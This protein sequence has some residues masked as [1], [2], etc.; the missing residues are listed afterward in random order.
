MKRFVWLV[1]LVLSLCAAYAQPRTITL[2]G[3]VRDKKQQKPVES[4]NVLVQ[5]AGHAMCGYA[6]TGEDGT[7]T[8]DCRVT[9]DT[10][11]LT[12]MAF[13]IKPVTRTVLAR[14]QR[15]DFVVEYSEMKIREVVVKPEAIK[16]RSDT[17]VYNVAAFQSVADRSI[18]DVLKKMPGITV[19]QS[20]AVKYNGKSINRFYV[21]GLDMMGSRYGVATKNIQAKDIAKVEVL[22]NHQPIRVLQG[23]QASDRAAV[24]LKLKNSARGTWNGTLQLGAGYAPVQWNGE[25][26]LMYFGRNFQTLNTYKTNNSGDDAGR[27]LQSFEGGATAGSL[28]IGV[29]AP[30]SPPVDR[31]RYLDN[32]VHAVSLNVIR[33]LKQ[34]GSDFRINA[35][36]LHDLQAA[37]GTSLTTCWR[38]D[39]P[40]LV[41][42]ERS[43]ADHRTDRTEVE[44]QLRKNTEKHYLREQL[45]FGGRWDRDAGTVWS[46]GSA[47]D[48][49]FRLPSIRLRNAFSDIVRRGDWSLNLYSTTDFA[50]Q[51]GELT[52]MPTP[53]AEIFGSPEGCPD[54]FQQLTS[55]RFRTDNSVS[56]FYRVKRWTFWMRVGAEITLERLTSSLSACSGPRER[57][58]A[59]DTMRNDLSWQLYRLNAGPSISYR[60]GDRFSASLSLPVELQHLRRNGRTGSEVFW[61]P[62]LSIQGT[63][64]YN[65]KYSA[66]ASCGETIGGI[67]D[68]YPGYIMSDYR[69]IASR[70]GDLLRTRR[71]NGSASLSYGNAIRALF[72]SLEGR[73]WRQR[74][75]LTYGTRYAGTLTQI[76][77]EAAPNT[78]RGWSVSGKLSKRFTAIATTV[79]LGG[80]YERSHSELLRQ[81]ERVDTRTDRVS[82]DAG[83]DARVTQALRLDYRGEYVRTQSRAAGSDPFDPIDFVHQ[84]AGVSLVLG[85]Q[86]VWRIG[87]EHYYN[88][89]I[90]GRDR[91]LWFLD[92]SLS[93]KGK[94]VEYVIEGSNL[95]DTRAFRSVSTSDLNDYVRSYTLRPA[96]VLFKVKFSLK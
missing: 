48:Q 86:W 41:I 57:L 28:P 92:A 58:E 62:S 39:A 79:N 16:R 53:Y 7:Y 3:C 77:T 69:Q 43:R 49:R 24:N 5:T 94:R 18:G 87:G 26:T 65:L 15:A 38:P 12:V 21:E 61:S 9:A 8:I 80:G 70:T 25:G 66:Q 75:N 29:H 78:S 91:N 44:L 81:G 37:R 90:G 68:T 54:A 36:Y 55:R 67:Y 40:P 45:T 89:A 95:L 2:K 63:I 73:Y 50:S 35:T 10:L 31:S 59:A 20:G 84:E 74:R 88:P 14:T 33:K 71:Q 23:V 27:E 83:L 52:V 82:A 32:Q 17:L 96:S 1:G 34:K 56:T 6:T 13:N 47:I 30:D 42:D 76:T 93:V 64:T 4:V 51:P 72:G 11:M 19:E 85:K 46:D 22:E 60:N